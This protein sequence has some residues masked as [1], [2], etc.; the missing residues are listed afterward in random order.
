[1]VDPGHRGHGP[2]HKGGEPVGRRVRLPR[3]AQR[4]I[5]LY[6]NGVEQAEGDDYELGDGVAI[7]H[8]PIIKEGK[9]GGWR[10]IS[11]YIGLFG[12]YR[13]NETVDAEYSLGGE[14]HLANNLEVIPDEPG[15]A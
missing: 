8:E 6:I 14:T 9:L 12:S 11:M 4:P 15:G 7:F 10:W 3:G 1:M 2:S 13:K 5:R